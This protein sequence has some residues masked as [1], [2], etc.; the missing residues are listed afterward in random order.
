MDARY[1]KPILSDAEKSGMLRGHRLFRELEPE[2]CVRLATQAK[3]KEYTEGATIFAKGDPGNCLF[4]LWRGRID[5]VN[6]S[7]DGKRVFLNRIEEGEIF[8]EIALL[9][10]QPRTADAIAMVD[11]CLMIIERREFLHL[12]RA[13]PD[14]AIRMLEIICG[15][16]RRTTEQVE[17][18]MFLD[19]RSRVAKT[20]LRLWRSKGGAE[21]ISISQAELSQIVGLS[22]E[23][24]NR[25]LQLW[26]RDGSI[27]LERRRLIVLR[28]NALAQVTTAR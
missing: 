6:T 22:R 18:L 9:D 23:M 19:L 28:P 20:I 3:M 8:G 7:Y 11:C 13:N 21:A 26:V 15:R 12:L 10:G 1:R 2:V 17:D 16:L 24:I 27:K 14:L 25:Q 4:A 5:I